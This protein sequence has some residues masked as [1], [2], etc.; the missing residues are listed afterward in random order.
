MFQLKYLLLSVLLLIS[1]YL[2]FGQ[3]EIDDQET[4][5]LRNERTFAFFLASNG[6]GGNFTYAQRRD[7]FRKRQ[8]AI[9]IAIIKHWKEEK[10][11]N[12]YSTSSSRFVYGKLN[13]VINIRAGIGKQK[14]VFY[15]QDRGSI[16][17]RYFYNYGPSLAILKPIYYDVVYKDSIYLTEIHKDE[18]FD[19]NN[20][21]HQGYYIIGKSAFVK[22]MNELK[23]SPGAFAKF[24]FTFEYSKKDKAIQAVEAGVM[25][26]FFPLGLDIM[27][28]WER[29]YYF[30]SFYIAYR[31]GKVLKAKSIK[32]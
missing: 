1:S 21:N 32:G 22:G 7:G 30:Y 31:F 18:K 16:S 13:T 12:L 24:G 3:G 26:E 15:K 20:P 25:A 14:E 6:W 8:Y 11:A 17:V 19:P 29:N 28:T 4:I 9:D 10:N 23:I 2:V 5:A 27:A